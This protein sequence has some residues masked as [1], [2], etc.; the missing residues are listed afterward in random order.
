MNLFQL[1]FMKIEK[2]IIQGCYIIE[3]TIFEDERGYFFESF[4]QQSFEELSGLKT[5]FVQ[6]NQSQ[7]TY[8]VV[9][10]LH[11]QLGNYA[12]AKLVRVLEGDVMDVAVDARRDSPT[13]G[14]VVQVELSAE[15]KKQLFIP[16]GCLHGFSVISEKATF[17]YKCDNFYD[18]ASEVSVNPFDESLAINWKIATDEAI[19]SEKDKNALSWSKFLKA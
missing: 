9:R 5:N 8:G 4:N 15:N 12:Q 13:F 2:T 7:S 16:R 10:G 11:A 1:T 14:N 18:K 17:F 19:I 3:P 6:D